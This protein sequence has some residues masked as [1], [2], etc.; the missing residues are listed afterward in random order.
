MYVLSNVQA[1]ASGRSL[2]TPSSLGRLECL[3]LDQCS[4]SFSLGAPSLATGYSC[5]ESGLQ[6]LGFH[7]AM[8]SC[9]SPPPVLLQGTQE[10][11]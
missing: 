10:R 6:Q 8:K 3:Q 7:E 4:P 9:P 11:F 2:P 1:P 5:P